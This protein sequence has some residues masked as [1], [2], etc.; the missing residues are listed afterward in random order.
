MGSAA[1]K[2]DQGIFIGVEE[3]VGVVSVTRQDHLKRLQVGVEER[4]EHLPSAAS[5][6]IDILHEAFL[7]VVELPQVAVYV[8]A[9]QLFFVNPTV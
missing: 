9:S 2:C 1:D 6:L 8:P 7:T 5:L 4:P 3:P